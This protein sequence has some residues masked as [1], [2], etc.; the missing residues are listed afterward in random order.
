METLYELSS[1]ALIKSKN[2]KSE[3]NKLCDNIKCEIMPTLIEKLSIKINLIFKL[4]KRIKYLENENKELNNKLRFLQYRLS[5]RL[6]ERRHYNTEWDEESDY[7]NISLNS[8]F[9][10][11]DNI[12]DILSLS[13]DIDLERGENHYGYEEII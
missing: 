1:R 12:A 7:D 5:P 3:W 2:F 4:E 9:N 10:E 13:I 8:D 11:R 6:I